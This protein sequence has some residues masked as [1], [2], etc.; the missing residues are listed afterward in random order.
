MHSRGTSAAASAVGV[1]DGLVSR[2]VNVGV[3][4]DAGESAALEH[5]V[6]ASIARR[7]TA[8]EA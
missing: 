8:I 1:G 2:W 6:R 7:V 4:E 3:G 5:E